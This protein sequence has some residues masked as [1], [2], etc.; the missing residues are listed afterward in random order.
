MD[1]GEEIEQEVA[2]SC[3]DSLVSI[4]LEYKSSDQL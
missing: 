3:H 4:S 1:V 2:L